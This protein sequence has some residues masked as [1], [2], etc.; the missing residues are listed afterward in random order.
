[1]RIAEADGAAYRLRLLA[2][3]M[4]QSQRSL[5]SRA[6][7]LERPGAAVGERRRRRY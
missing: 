7:N 1:M 6:L 3:A 4:N 5:L 2:G